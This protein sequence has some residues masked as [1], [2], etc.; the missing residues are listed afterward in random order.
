[1]H[2]PHSVP[3]PPA[4]H[5]NPRVQLFAKTQAISKV[6]DL[7][8]LDTMAEDCF[9]PSPPASWR[10]KAMVLQKS[11][12]RG[13][14]LVVVVG[15]GDALEGGGGYPPPFPERPAYAQPLSMPMPSLCPASMA[16]VTDSARPQRSWQPP[17]TACLTVSGAASEVPSLLMHL[18]GGG[19]LASQC[20]ACGS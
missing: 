1:M 14:F 18:W 11:V 7:P 16:F 13:C 3:P 17:P 2:P 9:G 5:Q 4:A 15:G 6:D 19:G 20:G 8:G 12:W 10:Y